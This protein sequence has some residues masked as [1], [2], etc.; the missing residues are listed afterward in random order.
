MIQKPW[1]T[2]G[3]RQGRDGGQQVGRPFDRPLRNSIEVVQCVINFG[4]C[5]MH[6]T[7]RAARNIFRTTVA[8]VFLCWGLTIPTVTGAAGNPE[9]A[10]AAAD[11]A[12]LVRLANQAKAAFRRRM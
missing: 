5:I 11:H 7:P 2:L 10:V 9:A 4:D 1:I 3:S 8:L 12:E 6:I